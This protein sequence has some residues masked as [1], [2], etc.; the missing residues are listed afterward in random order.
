MSYCAQFQTKVCMQTLQ[1]SS[2]QIVFGGRSSAGRASGSQS[3]G[4]GFDP[5]RLHF[6]VAK[7]EKKGQSISASVVR[8]RLEV[9]HSSQQKR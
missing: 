9:F 2:R 1:E 8:V 5:L 4:R 6:E 3:E 7:N